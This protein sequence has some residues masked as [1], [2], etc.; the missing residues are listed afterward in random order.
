LFKNQITQKFVHFVLNFLDL[1]QYVTPSAPRKLNQ[2]NLNAIKLPLPPLEI[3]QQI[4][5]EITQIE[6]NGQKVERDWR[7]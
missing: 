2:S 7:L 3:Q 6:Q 5:D 4:T 1:N